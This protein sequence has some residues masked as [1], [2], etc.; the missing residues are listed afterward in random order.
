MLYLAH[1]GLYTF[2]ELSAIFSTSH[3]RSH[4]K[5]YH[6]LIEQYPRYLT[7]M[8]PNG[9]SLYYSG[10]TYTGFADEYGVVFLATRQYL[11][12]T[13]HLHISTDYRI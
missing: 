1:N 10:F 3:D 13:L 6:S 7:L 12:Q 4:I 5:S 9:K 11:Y 2:F 8:Y